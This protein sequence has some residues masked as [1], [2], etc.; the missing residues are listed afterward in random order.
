MSEDDIISAILA[1]EGGF[2][3]HP[4]DK[5]GPTHFGVTMPALAEFRRHGVTRDDIVNLTE[6]EARNL[7]RQEFIVEPGFSLIP[8]DQLR[9]LVIDC[10][11]NHGPYRAKTLLQKALGVEP[12]GVF[13]ANTMAALMANDPQVFAR[14]CAERARYYGRLI[15]QDHSQAVFASGW[16]NR[17]AEFVEVA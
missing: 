9:A 7:Y 5:G 15:S 11:V 10:G 6:A 16:M 13:G 12:D 8:D 4:A 17:L 14:L 1:R 3:D 2:V